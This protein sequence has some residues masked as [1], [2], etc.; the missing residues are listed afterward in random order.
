MS[1]LDID[2]L[3]DCG[4]FTLLGASVKAI[5]RI[6]RQRFVDAIDQSGLRAWEKELSMFE[7][8]DA[9]ELRIY[10]QK[11]RGKV[12]GILRV[13]IQNTLG[14]HEVSVTFSRPL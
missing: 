14:L 12:Y 13:R 8:T 3:T 4:F 11:Y 6:F 7:T 2:Y 1:G 5:R 10:R 9:V